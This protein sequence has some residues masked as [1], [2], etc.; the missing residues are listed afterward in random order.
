MYTRA[1]FISLE[2]DGSK[3]SRLSNISEPLKVYNHK[4][5]IGDLDYYKIHQ[6]LH[7]D[8]KRCLLNMQLFNTLLNI[9][10]IGA[11]WS[12]VE[13]TKFFFFFAVLSLEIPKAGIHFRRSVRIS[14]YKTLSSGAPPVDLFLIV[15]LDRPL[16][17]LDTLRYVCEYWQN[18]LY[19]HP[20]G[21]LGK[22]CISASVLVDFLVEVDG[23]LRQQQRLFPVCTWCYN[24]IY[25]SIGTT[26]W[27]LVLS[28]RGQ[29]LS[30]WKDW[31]AA[32]DL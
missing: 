28:Y 6:Y 7:F 12:L 8:L 31:W 22:W 5:Y 19:C 9:H 30:G 4:R 15:Q 2:R 32:C 20:G 26:W 1:I 13:F 11:T 29:A 16:K 10:K 14:F 17:E 25:S 24:H 27:F 23:S 3:F 18:L 21:P